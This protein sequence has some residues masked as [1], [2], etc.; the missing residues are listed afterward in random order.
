MYTWFISP[1]W[2]TRLRAFVYMLYLQVKQIN[3]KYMN[4]SP[5]QI[6]Q[7]N[8]ETSRETFI[9]VTLISDGHIY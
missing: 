1:L 3:K 7:E 2:T 6:N 9:N 5:D 4:K 8:V